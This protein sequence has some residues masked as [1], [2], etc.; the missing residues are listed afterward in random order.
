MGN[1]VSYAEQTL[2]T[3][4]ELE[5]NSTDSLI[6]SWLSY[7]HWSEVLPAVS[8]WRGVRFAEL[9]R[10]ERFPALFR[11]VW[12][13]EESRKLFTAMVSSP[14]YR[15][16]RV[17]GYT[18]KTDPE[19]EK[20]FAAVCFQLKPAESYVAFRGTDTTLVGW[21]EDFN[22]AFQYPVPAQREAIT[23]L[24]L[25]GQKCRG[26]FRVGGH[27]K[28]GNLAICASFSGKASLRKRIS[29]IYS[30]D[31]PGFHGNILRSEAFRAVSEKIEKT[32]PQDSVVGML[33]EQQENFLVVRSKG[34]SLWQHDPF[35]WV[36][37][38]GN[39]CLLKS[40][41][42]NA[43]YV[44]HTLSEWL[45]GLSREE[46]ERFVDA[47]YEVL[48]VEKPESFPALVAR[49]QKNIP[50]ILQAASDMDEDTKHFMRQTLKE[51][52]L[53][54]FRNFPDI[55]RNAP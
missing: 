48:S 30:H 54:C 41:T 36:I 16:M 32:L 25:A 13:A 28:G 17:R 18:E 45:H 20:Q 55:F 39:F 22:M 14:R 35:S 10:A 46:R 47:L 38:D 5:F 1:I 12:Q 40:L 15:N 29:R 37:E 53:L 49:W 7:F 50:A 4:E 34:F 43:R 31:G 26:S 52:L 23:Y 44:N 8:S 11:E 3:F 24:E 27:S 33:L 21:K 19:A 9:F 42:S 2:K 6:L 51:L